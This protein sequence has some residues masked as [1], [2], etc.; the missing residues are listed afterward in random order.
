MAGL[1]D[2]ALDVFTAQEYEDPA[3]DPGPPVSIRSLKAAAKRRKRLWLATAF[4]GLVIGASLHVVLP[5]KATA[6]S[7]LYLVELPG[8]DPATGM[9][10]EVSL[11][12]T[13]TVG[14]AAMRILHLNPNEPVFSYKGSGVGSSILT[15][16]A[17]GTTAAEAETRANAV[18]Q[19]FLKIRAQL[20]QKTTNDEIGSL[21][22]QV[23]SLQAKRNPGS[24][25]NP[26]Q[27]ATDF[28]QI[29]TLRGQIAQDE[30]GQSAAI[31]DSIVLDKAYVL[32]VSAKKKA[33]KDGLSGLFG[34]LAF[35]IA[36]VILSELLSDRVRARSDV[37][38]ALGAPVELSV[39]RLA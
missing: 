23:L 36:I 37:A 12:E 10:N 29:T 31:R 7:Q 14:E 5:H 11:L 24:S 35:G 15:I 38:A 4:A 19:A 22:A 27:Q 13:Q 20:Q 26:L 34:G 9:A 39:R 6:V 28:G 32:P 25:A 33:V 18:A 21:K 16:N 1:T 3:Y 8:T 30:E 2:R 17:N